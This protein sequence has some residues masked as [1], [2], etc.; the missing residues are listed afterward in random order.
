[1]NPMNNDA[2]LR[3]TIAEQPY[4][5]LFVTISG[6]HLYGFPSPDS[7]VDMR[8]VH[9]LPVP[10]IS[11]LVT[12]NETLESSAI[13]DGLEIDLVSHDVRKFS[14]MLLKRNGY[15]LE[16]LF[17]PLIIHTTPEHE[18][19]RALAMGCIT[20]HHAHHYLGFADNQ[21]RLFEKETPHRVKALLYVFRVLLTGIYLMQ[22]GRVE[23]N[24][25]HLNAE[26][27][28]P[29]IPELVARKLSGAE[30]G[31]LENDAD[32]EFYRE[33]VVRLR[34][35]LAHLRDVTNLP[36]EPNNRAAVDDFLVRVRLNMGMAARV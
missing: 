23:A 31:T 25:L 7:D 4:P 28:L 36:E 6:A 19:L 2:R 13:R 34:G 15:V 27:N 22:T 21:W 20:R 8:G 18:E 11:R 30:T 12:E 3:Q 10:T 5:L 14:A 1:M 9:V 35:L 24:L 33:E 32:L 17:S 16:Q 29:Y 26:Y